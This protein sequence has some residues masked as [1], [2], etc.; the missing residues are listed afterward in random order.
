MVWDNETDGPASIGGEMLLGLKREAA[1]V[2]RAALES[3]QT[4]D[5]PPRSVLRA[6][7]TAGPSNHGE[8]D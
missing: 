7:L 6:I 8:P 1:D 2:A 4:S 5:Q 3:I